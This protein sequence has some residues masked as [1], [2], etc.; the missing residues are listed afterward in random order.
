MLNP[1]TVL[2]SRYKIESVLGQGG[3]GAVYLAT[4]EALGNKKVA[5]KEMEL[6]GFSADELAQAVQQFNKEASFLA[7][8]DHPNLVPVTDFFV[9][10]DKHYLVMAYITGQTLQQKLKAHGRPFSWETVR[11]YAEPLVN[12]LHYL[13]TQDPPILFRDLKPS[14]IMI[15]ESGR[16][17]LIDFGIARTAQAGDKTSTFLQGTGTSGFSPIEQYG[18]A[19][20]TDQRS[21][22]YA[23]G[24]TLYYLLTGKIP[25]DAV[26][27]IS[28]GSKVIAPREI[29]PSLPPGV[30]ELLLKALAV[31]Q[32]DRHASMDEFKREMLAI[33][34]LEME[35]AT[36]DFGA[37]PA[38]GESAKP[39]AP[40]SAA[41]TTT[42]D[43]KPSSIVVEM[44]PTTSQQKP[45]HSYTPWVIGAG[46]LLVA[47][48]AV[49]AMVSTFMPPSN[50]VADGNKPE[51]TATRPVESASSSSIKSYGAGKPAATQ[52]P[53]TEPKK[54]E[55]PPAA[56]TRKPKPNFHQPIQ[57]NPRPRTASTTT[58]TKPAAKPKPKT[59]MSLGGNSYPKADYPKAKPVNK[60]KEP[61]QQQPVIVERVTVVEK[62]VSSSQPETGRRPHPPRPG[63]GG[64][65]PPPKYDADGNMLPPP[66]GFPPPPGYKPSTSPR[67]Y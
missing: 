10:E 64:Q 38:V 35:G 46:S 63:P 48:F 53:E 50:P 60:P 3:M 65:P 14:N 7:H 67:G 43:S 33:Q 42:P 36:E 21:D 51:V 29:Q 24:A 55:K 66:P 58:A 22:I 26:A 34:S 5:V 47:S 2:S 20:S 23:L 12:V 39:P 6:K 27:R 54:T 16:L 4:M 9:E 44:F 56:V 40:P 28:Q 17:R 25:P 37:L 49:M 41:P 57:R 31:R 11:A 15:E 61:V 8:L 52:E 13:H 1:G 32:P 18:G 45:Q 19:Q 62:P 59:S 30:D